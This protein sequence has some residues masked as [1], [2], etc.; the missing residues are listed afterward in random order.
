MKYIYCLVL[1]IANLGCANIHQT[2]LEQITHPQHSGTVSNIGVEGFGFE[3]IGYSGSSHGVAYNWSTGTTTTGSFDHSSKQYSNAINSYVCRTLEN[4]GINVRSNHPQLILVGQIGTGEL[5]LSY[6]V[7]DSIINIA[8]LTT[9]ALS[10]RKNWC[11]IRVY[12]TKGKFLKEYASEGSHCYTTLGIPFHALGVSE[13]RKPYM[14]ECAALH[15][16]HI[17]LNSFIIDLNQDFYQR[18]L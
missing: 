10:R 14:N 11:R 17:N 15:A 8:S 5:D 7:T 3:Y 1:I 4:S 16:L 6:V 13:H 18:F 2:T 12:N 9:V